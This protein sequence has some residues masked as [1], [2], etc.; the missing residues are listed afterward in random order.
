VQIEEILVQAER[1][2]RVGLSL[3]FTYFVAVWIAAIWWTF[4]DIRSRSN[5]IFLQLAATLLVIVFNFPGLLIYF[6]LRPHRT[7]ADLYAESLE[8]EALLKSVN[9][10]LCPSCQALLSPTSC[11]APGAWHGCGRSA[12]AASGR[13]CCGGGFV[14]TVAAIS[15]APLSSPPSP[16]ASL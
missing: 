13:C 2:V 7:M 9:E 3:L 15:R 10:G 12:R 1:V 11:T 4:Q 14:P 8:E 6:F 16:R 5:D